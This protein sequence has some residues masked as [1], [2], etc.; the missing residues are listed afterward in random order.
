[1]EELKN[2]TLLY[3]NLLVTELT[4][5]LKIN[6]VVT[7]YDPDSPYMFCEQVDTKKLENITE[8]E[9]SSSFI[10]DDDVL[11]IKRY[12]KEEF[13]GGTYFISVKDIRGILKRDDYNKLKVSD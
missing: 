11:V 13:V 7:L 9:I 4:D 8:D 3:N 12:A 5:D 6:G 1:M 2:F 10:A